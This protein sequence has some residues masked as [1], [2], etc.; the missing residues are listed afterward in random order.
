MFISAEFVLEISHADDDIFL[1]GFTFD[2]VQTLEMEISTETLSGAASARASEFMAFPDRDVPFGLG[3]IPIEADYHHM[4]RLRRERGIGAA[5][6]IRWDHWRTQHHLGGRASASRPVVTRHSGRAVPHDEYIDE[7]LAMSLSPIEEIALPGLVSP[8]D[9]FGVHVGIIEGASD[10]VDPPLSFDILSGFV[11]RSDIV[12]DVSSMDLSILKGFTC[13]KDTEIVDLGTADQPRELKIGS[14]LFVD[15]RDNLIQLLRAYLDVFAWSYEDMSGLDPSIVQHRLPFLPHARP[16]KQK[17]RRLHPRW[18]L[19]VKEEIQKLLSVGFLSMVEYPSG[20]PMS[21]MFPKRKASQILMALEDMENVLHYRV[22]YL[23]LQIMPFGLKSAG[24]LIRGPA[25]T[26]FHDMMHRDFK[27]YVDDMIVKSRGRSDHLA[28][29]ESERGIEVDPD[30]IRAILDMLCTE[31]RER[32]SAR[33][34]RIRE[35]LLS[36]PVLAPPTRAALYSY[37]YPSQTLALG[38]MLAQLHDSARIEPFIIWNPLRYLFDRPAL[39]RLPHEMVDEDVAAVTSLSG[40]RIDSTHANHSGYGI[41][42]L[43]ISPHGDHIPRSIQG[44]WK[45]RD[46]EAQGLISCIFRATGCEIGRFEI[47]HLPRAQNQFAD[48]LATLAS[49]IDVPIDATVRPLLIESRSAPAYCCLIDISFRDVPSVRYTWRSHSCAALGVAC[50]D[51]TMVVFSVG[52]EAASYARLT[53]VGVASFIRSHIICRYGVPHELISDRGVHFRAEVDTLVQR[54]GIRHHKSSAYRPQTN[55]AV[56]AA[57]KNIKRIL[58]K[59]VETF[60]IDRRSSLSHYEIIKSGTRA[61]DSKDR[62]ASGSIDQLN[63]L[64]EKRLRAADHVCHIRGRWSALSKSGQAQTTACRE[65]SPEGAAW[66]M[67]LDGNQFSE[68]TNVDQLKR[69]AFFSLSVPITTSLHFISSHCSCYSSHHHILSTVRFTSS[70]FIPRG[71]HPQFITWRDRF[72]CVRI[73]GPFMD[74]HGLARSSSFKGCSLRCGRDRYLTEPLET[75][76]ARSALLDTWMPSCFSIRETCLTLDAMLGHISVRMRFTDHEGVACLSLFARFF[77]TIDQTSMAFLLYH[78]RRAI[79]FSVWCLESVSSFRVTAPGIHIHWHCASYLHGFASFLDFFSLRY[80]VLIAYSSRSPHRA[81]S[82][83]RILVRTP[84]W[85]DRYSSL[86]SI[87]ESLWRHLR[88]SLNPYV[89][90]GVSFVLRNQPRFFEA[91][92]GVRQKK[93]AT[94]KVAIEGVVQEKVAAAEIVGKANPNRKERK[95][96]TKKKDGGSEEFW[97]ETP[98]WRRSFQVVIPISSLKL[99][100]IKHPPPHLSSSHSFSIPLPHLHGVSR[101]HAIFHSFAY[102]LK[103]L[104]QA[105]ISIQPIHIL[106]ATHN[107]VLPNLGVSLPEFLSTAIPLGVSLPEFLSAAIPFG[108]LAPKIPLRRHSSGCFTSGIPLHR[109]S[110]RVSHT[111][112]SSPPPFHPDAS[113]PESYPPTFHLLRMSHIR[114]SIQLMFHLLHP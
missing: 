108:C 54:Y 63:L 47:T 9:L 13:C 101:V 64:D 16:V 69:G 1:T 62:L 91:A 114:N 43:L 25:T 112:N 8:F 20:W 21:S 100:G 52:V 89:L 77:T 96:G 49:M 40:W 92:E 29:L 79:I 28:A 19:Q 10:F 59:M 51:F 35:Y 58:R 71:D 5:C 84:G 4:A 31:D 39:V 53:S 94:E 66:L 80:P 32:V 12:S 48:A 76:P 57:N 44:K 22:G 81:V 73:T 85:F 2:E 55:G 95:K 70:S 65:L 60:R 11:S 99:A 24:A 75:H 56:E 14:D 18:S 113:H 30:K 109:H 46:A 17:L 74:P 106:H 7:M 36:P 110:I 90:V 38:C 67:D 87:F 26:L 86:T 82:F 41:G 27:V 3:F 107:H 88:G 33:V 6:I 98:S 105:P 68:L 103:P 97:P 104:I 37:T 78:H 72:S 61:A 45:T 23:L 42:V 34:E 83:R 50:I 93:V 15:E 102:P 111:R